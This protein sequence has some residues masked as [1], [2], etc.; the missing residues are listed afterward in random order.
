MRISKIRDVKTPTRG[1]AK[2]AG[3]DFYVPNDFEPWWVCRNCG[4]NI[5]SGIKANIP[6]GFALIAF[7]KSGIA[8][9]NGLQIG[10]CVADEDYQGEIH[11]HVVNVG[12]N[13]PVLIAP[14]MKLVQFILLPVNYEAIE[15][16]DENELYNEASERGEG[17][18]GSTNNCKECGDRGILYDDKGNRMGIC[19]CHN[20]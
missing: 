1:T 17:G 14:G 3:L 15:V 11:L 20:F 8:V 19:P 18:F 16:V 10:A 13:G 2:S 9:K 5:P 7:N 12:N 4:V 6:E